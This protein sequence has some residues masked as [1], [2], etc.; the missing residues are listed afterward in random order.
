M[1]VTI[2]MCGDTRALLLAN[3]ATLFS[4]RRDMPLLVWLKPELPISVKEGI[5]NGAAVAPGSVSLC[6]SL[7]GELALINYYRN[8]MRCWSVGDLHS[9]PVT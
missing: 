3:Y 6:T 9:H 7:F 4:C 8:S 5:S 2:G 1:Y